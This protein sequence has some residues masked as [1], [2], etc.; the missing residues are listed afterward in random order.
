MQWNQYADA[1]TIDATWGTSQ[2]VTDNYASA[3]TGSFNNVSA[4][5]SAITNGG[6][7]GAASQLALFRVF[8]RAAATADTFA[9]TVDLIGVMVA[10]TRT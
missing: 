10:Y 7:T 3:A 6:T 5:T 8:R 4:A 1:R 2:E 9:V